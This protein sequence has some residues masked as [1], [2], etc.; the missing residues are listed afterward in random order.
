[1]VYGHMITQGNLNEI[2]GNVVWLHGKE[3]KGVA[4][5]EHTVCVYVMCNEGNCRCYEVLLGKLCGGNAKRNIM[6]Q[7]SHSLSV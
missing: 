2:P 6:G 7:M 3:R 4:S 5:G 1:M